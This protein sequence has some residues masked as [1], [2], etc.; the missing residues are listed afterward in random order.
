MRYQL[1]DDDGENS[2]FVVVNLPPPKFEHTQPG[3]FM[4]DGPISNAVLFLAV[5]FGF[6]G[7]ILF[8]GGP[9]WV[10]AAVGVSLTAGLAGIRAWRPP[11]SSQN[12]TGQ[13]N[14]DEL[15]IQIETLDNGVP[16][17]FD[18]IE[19]ETISIDDLR[20]VARAVVVDGS[21][22]SRPALCSDAGIS[23]TTYHKINREF[24]R[25]NFA[26]PGPGNRT[27][28]SPRALAFLRKVYSL[29]H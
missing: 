6:T 23:Q 7:V 8:V 9:G 27:I 15:T 20:K 24:Q 29:P 12:V 19:D 11:E 5:L 25:L 16:V 4:A 1:I 26:H 21:N 18:E 2:G 17:M 3:P 28:L 10:A 13:G 22:F 14:S